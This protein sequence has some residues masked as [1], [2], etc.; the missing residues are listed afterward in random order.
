MPRAFLLHGVSS[1]VLLKQREKMRARLA[2][3]E[4]ARLY[5]RRQGISE[6][7]F[8][9]IKNILGFRRFSLRG[10]D[11]VNLEWLLV[12]LAYNCRKIA[13]AAAA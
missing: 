7:P 11:K 8:Y 4:G 6:A 13:A 1:G 10:L 5:G 3:A 9:V 12:A 2:Q